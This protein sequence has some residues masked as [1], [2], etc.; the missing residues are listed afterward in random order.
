MDLTDVTLVVPTRNEAHNLPGFLASVPPAV[1][2]ILV[3]A[4]ED[5]T[6]SIARELRPINTVV[7]REP[8]P[9]T[10]ARQLGAAAARTPWLLFSD[11]DVVFAPD[12]FVRLTDLPAAAA[13]YGPKLSLDAFAA[14]YAWFSRGQALAQ[15]LGV[16]AVSGSNLLVTAEAF[17]ESGGFDLELTCNEDSELGWR[18]RRRG[19]PVRFDPALRVYARD[20]R[21]LHRGVAAKTAH[22]LVR[23]ALLYW[24][25]LPR[26][27]RRHDWGYW[28]PREE[29]P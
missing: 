12:Y 28:R 2:V 20:H 27:W 24:N 29:R 1:M 6:P 25:L 5:A 16:P 14:Y 23:C 10:L 22:T 18:L 3:D 17:W 26:R 15:R 7:L 11:A 9:V 19:W 4:S 13:H 21:R 8:A